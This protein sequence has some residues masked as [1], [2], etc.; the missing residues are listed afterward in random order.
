MPSF[1][2]PLPKSPSTGSRSRSRD[3]S[4]IHSF[5]TYTTSLPALQ[6]ILDENDEFE[7]LNAE[8][9]YPGS[10]DL[11]APA[12]PG[13]KQYSL[14]TRSEL[15]FSREHLEIIF[16]DPSLL[17]RFTNFL[18]A[19]RTSSMPLL[20]YYLD[21]LK[22]IKAINYANGIAESLTPLKGYDF[23]AKAPTP[24]RNHELEEKASQALDDMVR[25][26]LP[27]YITHKYIQPVSLSIQRRITGTLPAHL[28]EASEGLAEGF[29]LTDPSRPDNLIVFA[30]EG[31]CTTL[32]YF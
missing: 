17:I 24:T 22:S 28:I 12:E 8:D 21:A 14:E 23:T 6:K 7:P 18:S 4:S 15:L 2:Y 16:A 20:V 5:Q 1:T 9:I 10:F 26:N 31:M 30:S 13:V 11:A 3:D 25:E 32:L 29:C 27:A 19:H